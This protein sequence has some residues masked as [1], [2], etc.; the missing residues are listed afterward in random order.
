M[1]TWLGITTVAASIATTLGVLLSDEFLKFVRKYLSN[2]LVQLG[3]LVLVSAGLAY[4]WGRHPDIIAKAFGQGW[5]PPGGVL[6]EVKKRGSLNCGVNGYLNGFSI[7]QNE[8]TKGFDADFCR[9]VAVAIT[10]IDTNLSFINL[11]DEERLDAVE[12]GKVDVL[13]RNTSWTAGRDLERNI[14]FGPPTY[15]DEQAILVPENSEIKKVSDLEGKSICVLKGTTSKEN[16]EAYL[17]QKNINFTIVTQ[18]SGGAELKDNQAVFQAYGDQGSKICDAVT[19]DLSQITIWKSRLE[20][21]N[22]HRVLPD[23]KISQELLSPVFTSKDEQWDAV[24]RYVIYSTIRAFELGISSTNVDDFRKSNELVI[25]SFLGIEDRR[26]KQYI[27]DVL[28]IRPDFA[29]LVIKSVGNYEEIYER[30]LG[31]LIPERGYN[32]LWRYG[33]LLISPPFTPP[34]KKASG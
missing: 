27:G 26:I 18:R 24:I 12:T 6:A 7:N 29:Y 28:G 5:P 15:Y 16:I 20:N 33:G 1:E 11:T 21:P 13:F 22:A 17:E 32:T 8:S 2:R 31:K 14:S 30:N 34:T 25:T 19:S 23:S 3:F 9:A 10:G 4:T